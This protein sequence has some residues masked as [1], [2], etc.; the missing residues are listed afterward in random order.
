MVMVTVDNKTWYEDK[1]FKQNLDIYLDGMKNNDDLVLVLDGP[2][3][4]GKSKRARQIAKYC[5]NYLGTKFSPKNV[6]FQ[7]QEYLDFSIE[8]PEYTVCVLDEARNVLNKKSSMS[9]INKKFT[10]YISE[11][12]KK[13]QVH[14]ICLP[15]FHD[16]DRYISLWRMKFVTNIN[17]WYEPD[18]TKTS[19]FKLARGKYYLYMNDVYLKDSYHY[20]YKYPRRWETIGQFNDIEVFSEEEL[21]EYE[22]KK[23]TN[24]MK[25]YHS[26]SEEEELTKTEKKWKSRWFSVVSWMK[27]NRGISV[28][29]LA[30]A[31]NMEIKTFTSTFT[32]T[33]QKS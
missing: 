25:K 10:N 30:D 14:I 22:N 11:C 5:A 24:I 9:K 2:E 17:K 16:L 33:Q 15:A 12:A 1:V 23:D 32:Q 4:S 29:E 20:P 27:I 8:S 13:R 21:K 31:S 19:G 3:R 7:L 18:K 6:H 28:G 26:S